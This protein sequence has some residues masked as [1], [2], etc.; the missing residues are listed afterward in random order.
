LGLGAGIAVAV[1]I[2]ILGTSLRGLAQAARMGLADGADV[3]VFDAE[4]ADPPVDLV[5]RVTVLPTDW[6]ASYLDG[7]DLVVTSPWFPEVAPPIADVL[8][9]GIELITEAGFALEHVDVP[10]IAVTGTN[11]KTTVTELITDMLCASGTRAIGAGN[12]GSAVSDIGEEPIDLLV[13]ELSSYQLRFLGRSV[14]SA[15]ALLNIAPDHLDWHGTF[16]AYAD[17]KARI[18]KDMDTDAILAYNVEDEN[19]LDAVARARCTLVPCS[20]SGVPDGGNGAADGRVIINGHEFSTTISDPSF[21]FDLVV[22]GTLALACGATVVGVAETIDSFVPGAHRRQVV[23]TGDGITWI[24][25]S[26]ATN[27]HAAIAAVAAH[28]PVIL[29]AGGQNKGLDLS[30][31]TRLA[32][33]SELI[34]FGEAGPEIERDAASDVTVVGTLGA[35]I[36]AARVVAGAGDT[37]LLSPGCA[38]FDEFSSYAERGDEFQRMV[39]QP[40]A[41]AT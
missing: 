29:L 21:L 7:V 22:A 18:F 15:A 26:K 35:A 31:I 34:A 41:T 27:P 4:V 30:P 16:A 11:G 13:L 1:R 33:V 19:V 6:D 5:D 8:A 32:G 38:S 3:V 2:L 25:D 28:A 37:V 9:A 24:D 20:G 23:E 17:A 12:V 40:E 36:S 39:K 10:F 14:P